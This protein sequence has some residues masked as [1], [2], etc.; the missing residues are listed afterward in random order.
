MNWKTNAM[1]KASFRAAMLAAVLAFSATGIVSAQSNGQSVG[2][3]SGQRIT[4]NFKDADIG[5][6]IE[7][8]AA[9]TGKTI[10]PDPRVR[11]TNVTMLSQTPMSP[12]AFYE[13]FL[14]LLQVHQYVAVESGG[15]IRI[16]PEANARQ[17]PNIDLP[18][19][20]NGNSD[21][22]ITQV[23]AVENVNA[24]QLVPVLRPLMP[25]AA[26][27]AAYPAGNILILSDHASN[28]ARVMRIIKRIDQAGDNDVDIINLQNA[29]AAEVVRV[30][31][32]FF[33][34][35]AAAEGGGA[36]P[37]R[38]IADDRSNSVLIGGDKNARLRIKALVA[39]LDTPL[40]NGGDTQVVY[41]QYAD[42]EKIA[43]KLKEQISATVAITGGPPAAGGA[44]GGGVAA[45]A[46]KSTTIWAEPE[47]NAL[48]ITAPAKVMRSLRAIVDKLDIRRAQVLVEAIIVD[49]QIEKNAEL[50]VNWAVWSEDS[51]NLPVG[52]FQS[53]VAG[54]NLAQLAQAVDN[55]S[56]APAA[57]GNGTTFGIGRVA[58][59]GVNFA[60]MIRA[61][62]GDSN[63]NLIATPSTVTMDN[64]E[65]QLKVAQE[66][67]FITGQF[68]NTGNT[69]NGQVSPFTTVQRQEVGTILKITPQ[70]NEGG[71]LVQL[72]IDI[73]SSALSGATGDANSAITNKRTIS[74]NVLIEDGGIVVLGGL[75]QDGDTR[76]EQRVPYLGR[77]PVIGELFKTRNRKREKRNLM[78]FIR[79]KIL[80]DGLA[81]AIE[82][83][84]KYNYIRDEQI[85]SMRQKSELL[86]LIPF[87]PSPTLPPLPAP[88]PPRQPAPGPVGPDGAP[89]D[90]Q[91]RST[92][93]ATTEPDNSVDAPQK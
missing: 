48:V 44:G 15:I 16:L 14:A 43:T 45:S 51:S 31:N 4:P 50:G 91:P 77:I 62:Q 66:V 38:V 82:T 58:A 24:A 11:S 17:M 47:T 12:D 3:I 1:K 2:K 85:R 84:A 90:S 28:V 67:P 32:T 39:H 42:A 93:P 56:S 70:V 49:V 79:P 21:E 41:L 73:E 63:T 36:S 83:D 20:V 89:Q 69:N 68:T 37:T 55:P 61:V 27:M 81:A 46:D 53:Q 8:V 65:A 33:A 86:P 5:T 59:T 7:A 6:V 30:V 18:D 80:R 87:T 10:I 54:V 64:Q 71:A 52:T 19:R 22:L 75:I 26:H 23:I 29:S 74:T 78:V 72:K 25:Q 60:A 13:A 76:G 34:Q 92:P 9:A 35:Q 57:L 40:D 88:L